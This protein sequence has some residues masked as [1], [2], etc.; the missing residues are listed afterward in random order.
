MIIEYS[1]PQNGEVF[2][3][4]GCGSGE[5]AL[6]IAEMECKHMVSTF[7]V[8]L[9]MMPKLLPIVSEFK[10]NFQVANTENLPFPDS[11]FDKIICSSSLEHFYNDIK[12]LQEMKRVL[13]PFGEVTMTVDSL[14]PP[15]S[16]EIRDKHKKMFYVVNYYNPQSLTE[17]FESAGLEMVRCEYI[18]NSKVTSYFYDHILLNTNIPMILKAALYAIVYPF[19]LIFENRSKVEDWGYTLIAKGR[20]ID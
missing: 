4:I 18:L 1:S 12:S 19:C 7:Q 13:K 5:L 10:C 11:F 20:R 17:K 2:L 15:I 16:N 8:I 9:F 14:S 6:K 3:D